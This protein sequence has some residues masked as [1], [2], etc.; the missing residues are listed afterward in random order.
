[1]SEANNIVIKIRGDISD[2]VQRL[3]QAKNQVKD[4]MQ[5]QQAVP[6]QSWERLAGMTSWKDMLPGPKETKYVNGFVNDIK[7]KFSEIAE[8]KNN[9]FGQAPK[10]K[11]NEGAQ[12]WQDQL[13]SK[14]FAAPP[15][16][17]GIIKFFQSTLPN[18]IG[19]SKVSIG[20]FKE[21]ANYLYQ[22]IDDQIRM[23]TSGLNT[24]LKNWGLIGTTSKISATQQQAANTQVQSSTNNTA[25]SVSN[26]TKAFAGL[27]AIGGLVGTIS[28][29]VVSGFQAIIGAVG[30]ALV[31]IKNATGA[32]ISGFRG[33]WDVFASGISITANL[34]SNMLRLAG[35]SLQVARNVGG[36]LVRNFI[37]ANKYISETTGNLGG[38]F[39]KLKN[40][41]RQLAWFGF[42]LTMMGRQMS[43]SLMKPLNDALQLFKGWEGVLE[44]VALGMGFLAAQGGLTAGIQEMMLSAMLKLPDAG[45]KIIGILQALAA[46]FINIGADILEVA[47]PSIIKFIDGLW[48]LWKTSKGTIIATLQ[49]LINDI[50]PRIF[51]LLGEAPKFI[52][53]FVSGLKKGAEALMWIIDVVKPFIANFAELFGMVMALSPVMSLFGTVLFALSVPLQALGSIFG[54][55]VGLAA[56]FIALF[57]PMGWLGGI[58][59]VI[60]ALAGLNSAI[61]YFGLESNSTIKFIIDK[62]KDFATTIAN[63]LESIDWDSA[64]D[65]FAESFRDTLN[66]II[67]ITKRVF[68]FFWKQTIEF[69]GGL[70]NELKQI[71]WGGV[72]SGLIDIV[73]GIW[74]TISPAL[75]SMA[76]TLI[77]TIGKIFIGVIDYIQKIDWGKVWD[78]LVVEFGRLLG[79]I[80]PY[81]KTIT[82]YIIG[83]FIGIW[84]TIINYA[85]RL[86]WGAI[87]DKLIISIGKIWDIAKPYLL[88]FVTKSVSLIAT[89]ITELSKLDWASIWNEMISFVGKIWNII[90][91]YLKTVF[92]NVSTW[93]IGVANNIA[94]SIKNIDWIGTF[95]GIIT[96]AGKIWSVLQPIIVDLSGKVVS[97]LS[98]IIETLTGLDWSAMWTGLMTFVGT[99]WDKISP[100]LAKITENIINWA[101]GMLVNISATIRNA[102][103]AGIFNGIVSEVG[104]IWNKASPLLLTF[105]ENVVATFATIIDKAAALDWTSIWNGLMKFMGELWDKI[106]PYLVPIASNILNWAIGMIGN[107]ITTLGQTDWSKIFAGL[108]TAASQLWTNIKPSIDNLGTQIDTAITNI[109]NEIV[110]IMNNTD[111]DLAFANLATFLMDIGNWI[112]A[113][114]LNLTSAFI[115]IF[116]K[117][118]WGQVFGSFADFLINLSTFIG[119]TIVDPEGAFRTW[120]D[121]IDWNDVFF[122]LGEFLGGIAGFIIRVMTTPQTTQDK[123]K[124][125][126]N[127]IN[128]NDVFSAAGTALYNVI[129]GAIRG[130]FQALPDWFLMAIGMKDISLPNVG[131]TMPDATEIGNRIDTAVDGV[132]S[133]LEEMTGFDL[134]SI[135]GATDTTAVND[136]TKAVET[137]TTVNKDYSAGVNTTTN[138]LADYIEETG[139]AL[140][141]TDDLMMALQNFNKVN[142]ETADLSDY[143]YGHSIGDDIEKNMLQAHDALLLGKDASDQ[144]NEG[145]RESISLI[146]LYNQSYSGIAMGGMGTLT[147]PTMVGPVTADISIT[148][149]NVN[150]SSNADIDYLTNEISRKIADGIEGTL[151]RIR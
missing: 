125:W 69:L 141:S 95:N 101:L 32:I 151:T 49:E 109:S 148:F 87:F 70:Y 132:I 112:I 53:G 142:W 111:W 52:G 17:A 136:I 50:F 37:G 131:D 117:I 34:A 56:P 5:G 143:L 114:T 115:T 29:G 8:A 57:G 4:F 59:A 135:F 140:T 144:F 94:S 68:D 147:G 91:P 127:Q 81:I 75:I 11:W 66:A 76:Q 74:D 85:S 44:D 62:V 121:T 24:Q 119:D 60:T 42:R 46:L 113:R 128:L 45:M 118:E 35:S 13:N 90:S 58:L 139:F 77:K 100:D 110:E 102:D 146:D 150:L 65:I 10:I 88:D 80:S 133:K 82:E 103:W 129:M 78:R 23:T 89:I 25:K 6:A 134:S 71:N 55:I 1:M 123:L 31:A 63:T 39:N 41:G 3:N 61:T 104:K 108:L 2:L 93:A 15:A 98:G 27:G 79:F 106:S 14:K 137:A 54:S 36:D 40:V 107:V 124:G 73:H 9:M 33:V 84:G 38:L 47:Y 130:I 64:W 48:Q 99:L 149:D 43:R 83:S 20:A 19:A 7:D 105:V 12:R 21:N 145:I 116:N 16:N 96:E 126:F 67:P 28:S 22:G 51:A 86:D 26:L 122:S 120:I 138:S 92:D 30:T 97:I 18:A 72:F